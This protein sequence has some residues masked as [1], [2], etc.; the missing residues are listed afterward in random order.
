MCDSLFVGT[1]GAGHA[2][3]ILRPTRYGSVRGTGADQSTSSVWPLGVASVATGSRHHMHPESYCSA[4]EVCQTEHPQTPSPGVLC[5]FHPKQARGCSNQHPFHPRTSASSPG[6]FQRSNQA[7]LHSPLQ[8]AARSRT[9]PQQS[10]ALA[11]GV[12]PV[13]AARS[14]SF[15]LLRHT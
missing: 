13:S 9:G 6:C 12:R 3:L 10:S 14:T 15:I 1:K 7:V 2:D 8:S 11:H 4:G 5:A